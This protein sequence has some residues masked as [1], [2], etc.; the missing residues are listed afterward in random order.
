VR[1]RWSG[2]EAV[3]VFCLVRGNTLKL[4]SFRSVDVLSVTTPS[5]II[6]Y[7]RLSHSI[8]SLSDNKESSR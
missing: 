8:C 6:S 7:Y 5:E 2:C 4:N 3:P 1:S